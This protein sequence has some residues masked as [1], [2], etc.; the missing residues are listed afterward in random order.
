MTIARDNRMWGGKCYGK[1]GHVI[2]RRENRLLDM[3]L[4]LL[5][6]A[7]NPTIPVS[8]LLTGLPQK[9]NDGRNLIDSCSMI[10]KGR[11]DQDKYFRTLLGS[12]LSDK[13]F[14]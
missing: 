4:H 2:K 9:T 12:Y 8:V 11:G 3:K 13:L 6:R 10:V 1:H 7:H 5:N 14:M